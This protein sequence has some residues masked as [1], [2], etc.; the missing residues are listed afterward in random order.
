MTEKK[1][2][3]SKARKKNW[4]YSRKG[5]KLSFVTSGVN[6][7]QYFV[8][9]KKKK[10]TCVLYA[11]L[12]TPWPNVYPN[13][14]DIAMPLIYQKSFKITGT[15]ICSAKDEFDANRGMHIALAKAELNAY[16]AAYEYLLEQVEP[17]M[18]IAG[19]A[20]E[21]LH[22]ALHFKAHN[23][24]HVE[25]LSDVKNENYNKNLKPIKA[26]IIYK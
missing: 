1:W 14:A 19:A 17:T 23:E 22:K 12:L 26:K 3:F 7:P 5:F 11:G 25:V 18:W 24:E 21:F 20:A 9:E 8:D 13:D 16:Q 2:A 15:A 6:A 4:G 10:V